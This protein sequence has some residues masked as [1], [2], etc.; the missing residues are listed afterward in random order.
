MSAC[1]WE[2]IHAFVS[3]GEYRRFLLW[4]EEREREGICTEIRDPRASFN[5]LGDRRY[6]CKADGRIWKLSA[7]DPG[8]FAGSWLPE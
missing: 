1:N 2:E 7:P 6:E 3:L 5:P 4:I 8:Y